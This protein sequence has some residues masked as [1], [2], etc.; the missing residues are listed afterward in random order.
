MEY[1]EG[2]NKRPELLKVLCIL[3]FIGSGMSF[4]SYTLLIFTIDYFSAFDFSGFGFF[5]SEEQLEVLLLMFSLPKAYFIIHSVLYASSLF[6]A[7]MM[8]H[9]RKVGFH[10]YTA[11]Q[12]FILILPT[13]VLEG[14]P[15]SIIEAIITGAFIIAY[16]TQ[17]KFMT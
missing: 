13:V 11:A 5:Q 10:F 17:L 6:G 15:F 1:P 12:V 16:S 8:W 3:T 2:E 9:M 7:F 4:L 14:N